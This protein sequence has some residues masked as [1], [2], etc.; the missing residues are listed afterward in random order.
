MTSPKYILI[1]HHL[2]PYVQRTAIALNDKNVPYKRRNVDL[3]DK[4][5]WFVKLSPLGKVPLLLVDDETVLFESAVIAEYIDEVT[6]GGLLST[7]SLEKSRQRAWIEYASNSI[8]NV[9]RLY[10]ASNQDTFDQARNAIDT[11]WQ[12]L[13]TN[14]SHG[15]WFSGE[16]FS[17]VDAAFAPMFR[18]FEVFEQVLDID[19]FSAVPKVSAWRNALAARPSVRSAVGSDYH[20]RLMQFLAG[21]DSVVGRLAAKYITH[22]QHRVA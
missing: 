17:L 4:P 21:R 15:P 18:Y 8:V 19:F 11:K 9:G 12:T 13:D 10:N 2:C 14:L 16:D 5:D 7:D 22:D 6:G 20:E 3:S 1:S